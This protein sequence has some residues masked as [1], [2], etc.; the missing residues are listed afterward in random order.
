[1]SAPDPATT[2]SIVDFDPRWRADFAR[3]N[4]D[5]L[6]RWFVVEAIDAEVLGDP[7]THLLKDGGRVLFAIAR[8]ADGRERAVGTVALLHEGNGV[9]ELTKMA[10]SPELQGCGIGRQLMGAA[11]DAFRALQG[12]ELFLESSSKLAPALRL[13]ESVGFRHR[14]APRPGSHYARADVYMVWEGP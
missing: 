4:R 13:Y 3:L 9:Y 6:E 7:E 5:W 2:I 12:R 14:P 11:L 1:V 8:E 10:V